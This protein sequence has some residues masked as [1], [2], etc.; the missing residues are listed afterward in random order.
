LFLGS[1]LLLANKVPPVLFLQEGP[2]GMERLS[3]LGLIGFVSSIL[4]GLR[5]VRAIY[6]SGHLDR[7]DSDTWFIFVGGAA[8]VG[9]QD[10]F[11][12][13]VESLEFSKNFFLSSI[14]I[15]DTL[16][17]IFLWTLES[18]HRTPLPFRRCRSCWRSNRLGLSFRARVLVQSPVGKLG[19]DGQA[20]WRFWVAG[21]VHPPQWGKLD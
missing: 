11:D 4:V 16:T 1:S 14:D 12:A 5:L 17:S 15:F 8:S 7:A 21:A 13:S 20:W 9:L 19:K 3:L 2:F 6:K 10:G 18:D